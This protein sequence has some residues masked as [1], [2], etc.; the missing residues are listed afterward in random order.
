MSTGDTTCRSP[1]GLLTIA[2][3]LMPI[4][5]RRHAVALELARR[6][7]TLGELSAAS[8]TTLQSLCGRASVA[9]AMCAPAAL[10]AAHTTALTVVERAEMS[11]IRLITAFDSDYP[12]RLSELADGPAVIYVRG[13]LSSCPR[14][15]ACVGTREP[16]RFGVVVTRRIT[17]LLASNGWSIVSGLA[18]GVDTTAHRAALDAKGHTIA[19]LGHGLDHVYPGTNRGL[20]REIVEG[21]GALLS[22]EPPGV[23]PS[24]KRLV[25]R[26]RLQ[27]GLSAAVV[28]FQSSADGGSMHAVRYARL[29]GRSL[30]VPVPT[31]LHALE[32]KSRALLALVE[33]PTLAAPIRG[34]ADYPRFL[35]AL[36]AVAR[37]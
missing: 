13:E 30:F 36:E 10:A 9:A 18:L 21:G 6:F 31:G 4:R 28:I 27:S 2:T 22:E 12:L 35:A 1:E 5:R 33:A 7:R 11:S 24:P 3:L 8:P 15:V 19:V 34:R 26:D 20:A 37:R 23:K 32:P 17:R 29:Q 25:L 14:A 16:S